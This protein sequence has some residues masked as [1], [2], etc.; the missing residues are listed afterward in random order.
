MPAPLISRTPCAFKGTI[1]SMC[2]AR[3]L[4][5]FLRLRPGVLSRLGCSQFARMR[6]S[7]TSVTPSTT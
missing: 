6:Y 2:P 3:Q 1:C 7:T 5:P 4:T